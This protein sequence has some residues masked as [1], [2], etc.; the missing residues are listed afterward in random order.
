M[1][2]RSSS[3][4]P[5]SVAD[6]SSSGPI[7][8][9]TIDE[10]DRFSLNPEAV[11]YLRSL[12]GRVV[13]VAIAG[14]YRTGKSLLLNMLTGSG[15]GAASSSSAPAGGAGFQVG[16]T[17]RAQTRGMWLWGKALTPDSDGGAAS[18]SS[19]SSS[20]G[21]THYLFMDTEGLGSTVR[22]ETY[23]SRVFALTLL[24]SSFFVYNG[25]GVIDG[26]AIAKL[27]LIVNLTKHIHVRAMPSGNEDTG[28]EFAQF[29]PQLMWV[30]R[31][32]AV[33]LE[34]DGRKLSAREYLESALQPEDGL[35]EAVE[36][37]NSVRMLLRTFF[38][39]RDCVT[40]VR[41]VADEKALMGLGQGGGGG[42]GQGGAG[43]VS[44]A[45]MAALRPEFLT[46]VDVLRRKIFTAARPKSLYGKP[47]T[48]AMLASLAAAYVTALNSNATPTIATAWDRVVDT[49]GADAVE[50]GIAAY[51][52]RMRELLAEASRKSAAQAAARA[53]KVTLGAAAAAAASARPR[54][55]LAGGG[56]PTATASA[57]GGRA[58]R[59]PANDASDDDDNDGDNGRGESSRAGGPTSS[60]SSSSSSSGP[61]QVVED[62]DLHGAHASASATA[63]RAFQ[64][65]V[66]QDG[67]RTPHF[68][69]LF[70]AR[71][72]S[73]HARLRRANEEASGGLC[74]AVLEALHE[75]AAADLAAAAA[76]GKGA[77][78]GGGGG[79]VSAAT[80]G[81]ASGAGARPKAGAASSSHRRLGSSFRDDDED[82][83]NEDGENEDGENEDEGEEEELDSDDS[84]GR[85]ARAQKPRRAPTSAAA[86]PTPSSSSTTT[87]P[88]TTL[89]RPST[90]ASAYR[91]SLDAL[92]TAYSALARGPA[93]HRI[94]ADYSL[95]R[96]PAL[97]A[98]AAVLAD[99]T[100]TQAVAALTARVAEAQRTVT[101][102]AGKERAALDLL[103]QEKR[104]AQ[105]ALAEGSRQSAS[106]LDKLRYALDAKEEE[107][108]RLSG[109]VDR[110]VSAFEAHSVRTEEAAATA[111]HDLA[112]A[113]ARVEQV[114]VERVET[115]ME[116][117]VMAQRLAEAE[118]AKGEAEGA[119]SEVRARMEAEAKG[120][121]V[122]VERV[123]AAEN[124]TV[125]LREQ[126]ELLYE[127]NRVAKELLATKTDETQELEYQFGVAKGRIAALEGEKMGLESD[128]GVLESLAATMKGVMVRE[129]VVKKLVMDKAEGRRFEQLSGGGG[130]GAGGGAGAS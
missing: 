51:A 2:R 63:L 98:D 120:V 81:A 87:T 96:A 46:Q 108:A 109:K 37:R 7:P 67:E 29:F 35:S 66:I 4:V 100:V 47:L 93:K 83:E 53:S 41:P 126:T 55:G 69:E 44:A 24:L 9:V 10:H 28:T 40:M 129:K 60:S 97:L 17:V 14:M 12:T 122:L 1:A 43:G 119:A 11:A 99:G 5:P 54:A 117:A 34:R 111:A 18:S 49:Q 42:G 76:G 106:E 64:A 52:G 6:G 105:A 3:S 21:P 59:R 124:E 113:R 102:A 68:E 95:A 130:G 80:S 71:V 77:G 20:S 110:L 90:L 19:S 56:G 13:V 50:A 70:H 73:E 114:L 62:E 8:F 57:A 112:G 38:P 78:G 82:G 89:V 92:L 115:L 75:R 127:A 125:R 84:R 25:I 104:S 116:T 128:L 61:V 23:D 107:V 103:A 48:G 86:A 45:D 74:L 22:S 30:V 88:A 15:G 118:R 33:K 58:R 65:G 39:E 32:F 94:L 79:A 26:T 85:G 101:A 121:A 31:D 91:S 27:S 16:G 72:A 36:A 123:R